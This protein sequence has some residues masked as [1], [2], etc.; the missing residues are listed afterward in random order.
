MS[1][2]GED[3]GTT[4]IALRPGTNLTNSRVPDCPSADLSRYLRLTT[5]TWTAKTLPRPGSALSPDVEGGSMQAAPC[6]RSRRMLFGENPSETAESH[7]VTE[8][9]GIGLSAQEMLICGRQHV[10][11][12]KV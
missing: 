12:V 3:M 4:S 5:R 6:H 1:S 8:V 11:A 7:S 2:I 10:L 9:L